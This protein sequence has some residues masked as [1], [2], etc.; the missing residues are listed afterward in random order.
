[1]FSEKFFKFNTMFM[2]FGYKFDNRYPPHLQK[3]ISRSSHMKVFFAKCIMSI[4]VTLIRHTYDTID[5]VFSI[6]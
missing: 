4:L 3:M 1:M 5:F 6:I 2:Y